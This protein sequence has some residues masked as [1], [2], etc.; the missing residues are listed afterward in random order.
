MGFLTFDKTAEEIEQ[1]WSDAAAFVPTEDQINT[2]STA[3]YNIF[4]DDACTTLKGS[5]ASMTDD[6]LAA[7]AN[8]TALPAELQLAVKKVRD[9]SW[10]EDNAVAER[11]LEQRLR[12]EI[13]RADVRAI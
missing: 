11:G 12:Q 3:L 1:A 5:Y 9:N 7:D 6:Q 13:P 10:Q 4:S 8:Y 2:I